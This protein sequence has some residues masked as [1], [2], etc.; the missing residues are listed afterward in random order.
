ML[1]YTHK[2]LLGRTIKE[3]DT[4][5][6]SNGKYNTKLNLCTVVNSTPETIRIKKHSDGKLTNI[7]SLN[8]IV[9]TQQIQINQ[10]EKNDN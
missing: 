4:I 7:N 1:S 5:A 2:D 6:W 9:I 10:G 3:N 8:C